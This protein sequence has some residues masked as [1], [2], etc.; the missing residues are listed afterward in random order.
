MQAQGNA[1]VLIAQFVYILVM[2]LR[3]LNQQLHKHLC[4]MRSNIWNA[5]R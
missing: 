1:H 3:E 2:F 4:F 5:V